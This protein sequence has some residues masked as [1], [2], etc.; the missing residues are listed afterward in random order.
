[1]QI[2]NNH[3]PPTQARVYALTPSEAK[4]E[5][6]VVTGTLPL[7]SGKAVILFDSGATHSFISTK[8]ARRFHINLE[9]MKVGVVVSTP[10]SK[11]LICRKI[12]MGCPIQIEGRTLTANLI[13]FDMEGF[14]IILGMDWLSNNHAIIDCH[15]K[16][17]IFRL[18]ADSDFKFVGTKVDATPQLISATQA[19]Q[20]LLEGYQI[21]LACLKELPQ[22]ERNMEEIPV[23]Q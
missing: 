17:I 3:K 5:N 18:P 14:N 4:T 8:Y 10:V 1:L 20:L 15:N 7:L 19:K 13:V 6:G 16:E 22:E 9:P 11:S 2:R 21:Y 23:V 12:V